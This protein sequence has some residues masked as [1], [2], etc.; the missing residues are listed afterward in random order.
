MYVV[1]DFKWHQ[2]IVRQWDTIEVDNVWLSEGEIINTD[3]VLLCFDEEWKNVKIG[4]PFLKWSVKLKVKENFK[5]KKIYVRKFKNKIRAD[6][7]SKGKWFR[8][9]KSKLIV[10]EISL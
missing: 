5:W 10:E 8:P 1:I 6:R 4:T 9:I 3:K 2:W 7:N